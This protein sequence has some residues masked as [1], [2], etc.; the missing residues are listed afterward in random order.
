[1]W[2]TSPA[3]T[4]GS[5]RAKHRAG[6]DTAE[7]IGEGGEST[8]DK[9]R[10]KA[11]DLRDNLRDGVRSGSQQVRRQA[12]EV[13]QKTRDQAARAGRSGGRFVKEHPILVGAA[14]IAL[15]AAVAASL[16]RSGREDRAFGERA[17]SVKTAAKDAAV[18][19]GRK[20]QE[21]A[22]AAVAKARE[23]AEA[24]APSAGDLKRDAEQSAKAASD[25][26]K[27]SGLAN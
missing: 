19:E 8:T 7:V 13:G 27:T 11:G 4:A 6:D 10:H 20:V 15:G 17:D 3:A 12:A 2:W 21:A 26:K 23:T 22:K 1:M 5:S 14:G 25:P 9:L 16:P 18:K 24:K